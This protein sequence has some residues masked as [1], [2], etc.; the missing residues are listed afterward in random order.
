ME[1]LAVTD[2]IKQRWA[3]MQFVDKV[4]VSTEVPCGRMTH[5]AVRHGL[6]MQKCA[7]AEATFFCAGVRPG[8]GGPLFAPYLEVPGY[9]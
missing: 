2:P 3:V 8:P 5:N 4:K 7:P 9:K 1:A 6:S